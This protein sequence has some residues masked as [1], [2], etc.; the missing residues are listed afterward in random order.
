VGLW[1]AELSRL[2]GV[3]L[4]A[5]GAEESQIESS[6]QEAVR[7]AKE[8]KSVSLQKR[9]KTT[10]AE[11]RRPKSKRLRRTEIPTSSLSIFAA[12]YLSFKDDAEGTCD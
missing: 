9:A 8:Q 4:A 11:Y 2:R 1:Y 6:F 12:H 10:F 5:L 3:F 7:I